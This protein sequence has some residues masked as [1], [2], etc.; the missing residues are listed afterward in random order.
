MNAIQVGQ[1]I[2]NPQAQ[3]DTTKD[4]Q[5]KPLSRASADLR[6]IRQPASPLARQ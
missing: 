5:G 4:E 1:Q 2:G 3:P 6:H